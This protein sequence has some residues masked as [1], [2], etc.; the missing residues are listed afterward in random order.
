MSP[1]EPRPVVMGTM[2]LPSRE[3]AEGLSFLP[4]PPAAINLP[5]AKRVLLTA[6]SA[7]R[8]ERRFQ[9]NFKFMCCFPL[10]VFRQLFI[11]GRSDDQCAA[12]DFKQ[13][14][15]RNPFQSHAG[16]GG[17]FAWGKIR[18]VNFVQRVVLR[19]MRIEPCLAGGHGDTVG[20]RQTEKD[21]DME[22]AVHGAAGTLDR[23]LEGVHGAGDVL[24]ERVRD[25][26]VVLLGIAIIGTRAGEIVDSIVCMVAAAGTTRRISARCAGGCAC[27]REWA[28]N[29]GLRRGSLLSR[30]LREEFRRAGYESRHRPDFAKEVAA[31]FDFHRISPSHFFVEESKADPDKQLMIAQR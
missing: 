3:G 13:R 24:F 23:F 6:P 17:S 14:I 31:S 28:S 12:D 20:E 7:A 5:G 1:V 9:S 18:P 30:L 16:T 2:G 11:G 8:N 10:Q 15:A 19:F 26:D 22:D 29:W 4:K 25:E 21:L 27:R